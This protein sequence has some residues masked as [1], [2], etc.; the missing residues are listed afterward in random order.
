VAPVQPIDN[1]SNSYQ[2]NS[3]V[4]GGYNGN[5]YPGNG[6]NGNGT[7]G[8]DY[9]GNRYSSNGYSSNGYNGNGYHS[10]GYNGNGYNNNEHSGTGFAARRRMLPP[11]PLG[12]SSFY[13]SA[14]QK[15]KNVLNLTVNLPLI[16]F[17]CICQAESPTLTSSV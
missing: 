5:S 7:N 13:L 16:T 17:S 1:I 12:K 8:T 15:K 14:L 9:P 2:G 3:Q 6:Y 10:N 11:T 4:V